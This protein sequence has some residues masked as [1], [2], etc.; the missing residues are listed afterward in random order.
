[1]G[2][3]VRVVGDPDR[4]VLQRVHEVLGTHGRR[5]DDAVAGGAVAVVRAAERGAVRVGDLLVRGDVL[6]AGVLLRDDAGDLQR[7][8]LVLRRRRELGQ[9]L[10]L[11]LLGPV[12]G[13]AVAGEAHGEQHH[14]RDGRDRAPRGVPLRH[15]GGARL[16]RGL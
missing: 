2:D 8:V 5:V 13:D 7:R 10:L 14:H 15:H 16:T 4:A 6:T 9:G 12:R 1:A 11:V 3:L